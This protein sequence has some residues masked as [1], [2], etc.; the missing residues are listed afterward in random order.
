MEQAGRHR[1][2]KKSSPISRFA[3][4][5]EG[6]SVP[7]AQLGGRVIGTLEKAEQRSVGIYG[8]TNGGMAE[9][10]LAEAPSSK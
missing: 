6:S 4:H 2:G 10:E 1:L 9:D 7:G 3:T 8:G 5:V